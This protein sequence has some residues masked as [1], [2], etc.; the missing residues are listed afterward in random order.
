M[1]EMKRIT[2][3]VILMSAASLSFAADTVSYRLR[4]IENWAFY[5]TDSPTVE[6]MAVNG[7]G[8]PALVDVKCGIWSHAGM[9]MY[10]IS[11]RGTVPQYDSLAMSFAFKTMK[12]GF[13]NAVLSDNGRIVKTVNIAYEP[14]KILSREHFTDDTPVSDRNFERLVEE[15]KGELPGVRRQFSIERNKRMSGKEKNV[16]DFRMLSR[17]D[18]VVKGYIAFPRGK[19]GLPAMISFLPMEGRGENP[20]ADFT[21]QHDMVELVVYAGERGRGEMHFRNTLTDVALCLEYIMNR[22]EIDKGKV[23][24]QGERAAAGLSCVA[25]ALDNR[26]KAS[27]VSSPDFS[28]FIECF[29]AESV[30]AGIVAPLLFGMGLQ[31]KAVR[32]QEDFAVYN[33]IKG[34]KE[35]FI[36]PAGESVERSRWRYM[37]DTFILRLGE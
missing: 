27:F 37:R 8:V 22:P 26:V 32:L 3:I 13:Y 6:I 21:A 2:A 4:Q 24:T 20:L 19:K 10:E 11:Q 33:N 1:I 28:R 31:D 14:E 17:D 7:R 36:F 9:P 16:Y 23:Y 29:T 5:G 25:S 34:V 12:P 35:Y 30:A 18:K 15:V